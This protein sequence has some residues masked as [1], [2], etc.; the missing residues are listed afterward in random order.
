MRSMCC[1]HRMS[2]CCAPRLHS[3]ATSGSTRN[4]GR[5]WRR[6]RF[7]GFRIP[8]RVAAAA[9]ETAELKLARPSGQIG[10]HRH[11]TY[12]TARKRDCHQWHHGN[13]RVWA[14]LYWHSAWARHHP[15][16]RPQSQ[17]NV[18]TKGA[19][20]GADRHPSGDCQSRS[21]CADP[22]RSS[23]HRRADRLFCAQ[24]RDVNVTAST[25]VSN[26]AALSST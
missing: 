8:W 16:F 20:A 13:I 4:R 2:Q 26:V 21:G 1:C 17:C 25:A 9:C 10:L 3:R 5:N 19:R 18:A 24:Q 14:Q 22:H 12:R 11:H 6:H 15:R 23:Q 7:G